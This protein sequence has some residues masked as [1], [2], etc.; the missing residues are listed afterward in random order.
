MDRIITKHLLTYADAIIRRLFSSCLLQLQVYDF[1]TSMSTSLNYIHKM[2]V[3]IILF[4][5]G[6]QLANILKHNMVDGD[7]LKQEFAQ[8][9]TRCVK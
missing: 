7:I 8:L 3:V 5:E 9:K 2:V 6:K 1:N 4:K